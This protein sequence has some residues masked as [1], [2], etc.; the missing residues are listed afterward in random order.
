[1]ATRRARTGQKKKQEEKPKRFCRECGHSYDWHD[2][3]WDGHLILCRCP[4][5]QQGGKFCIFLSDE[6]CE[7]FIE[8]K[9]GEQDNGGQGQI[10]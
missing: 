5:K 8:R 1:M 7:N 9:E 3:A 2:K 6:A 4:F 10:Q